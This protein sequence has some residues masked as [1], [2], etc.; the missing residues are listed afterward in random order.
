MSAFKVLTILCT[1]QLAFS[2]KKSFSSSFGEELQFLLKEQET[3]PV[4]WGAPTKALLP[5]VPITHLG[6]H[7]L[8]VTSKWM[9]IY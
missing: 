5:R 6:H 9:L 1:Y 4:T 7:S 2:V 8:C 3:S